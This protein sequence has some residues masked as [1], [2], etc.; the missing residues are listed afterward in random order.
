MKVLAIAA[1][2]IRDA[3]RSRVLAAI[4]V[5][6]LVVIAGVPFAVT[7]DGTLFGEMRVL[8][9]YTLGLVG[10]LLG[11]AALWTACGAVARD[12]EDQ[13]LLLTAVKPVSR[14]C[15]WIGRWLGLVALSAIL[16]ALC[17]GLA[18]GMV[19]AKLAGGGVSAAQRREVEERILV[20]R[21]RIAARPPPLRDAVAERLARLREQGVVPADVPD[22]EAA[23][24]IRRRLLASAAGTGPGA[25]RRWVFDTPTRGPR[26]G[27]AVLRIRPRAPTRD[28]TPAA[29]TWTLRSGGREHRI[30]TDALIEGEHLLELPAAFMDGGALTVDFRND[31]PA[32]S[33]TVLFPVGDSAEVL[34]DRTGFAANLIRALFVVLCRL[35]ALTALGLTAGCLFS[36][37]VAAFAGTGL[38]CGLLLSRAFVAAAGAGTHIDPGHHGARGGS[39]GAAVRMMEAG[40]AIARP[41][42]AVA[43]S[44]VRGRVLP[45]LADGILLPGREVRAAAIV[46]GL[47]YPAG[48]AAV[49]SFV[50]RRRELAL[51]GGDWT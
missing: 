21:Q 43:A 18:F 2:T 38:V 24:E 12:I 46:L 15:I 25:A 36:L 35:A 30:R 27:G 49:G 34:I 7:G 19:H 26:G 1:L 3:V 11:V 31:S 39:G 8:L 33:R 51:P 20:G 23:A 28:M 45:R 42:A 5:L 32:T 10:L 44:T 16:L 9:H 22:R 50:L 47:L 13:H 14:T 29:G 37:P 6:L 40:E 4:I 48:F 41:F 17:G